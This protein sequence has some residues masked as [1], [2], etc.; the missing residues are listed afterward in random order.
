MSSAI[1]LFLVQD[2]LI[3]GA[4]YGLLAVAIV[5]VFAVTRVILVPQ[6]EFVTYGALTL[7]A[8]DLGRVPGTAWLLPC[9]G[10]V[11]AVLTLWRERHRLSTGLVGR[12]LLADIVLPPVLLGLSL[13]LA[14]QKPGLAVTV[15]LTMALV[16]PMGPLVYRIAFRPLAESSILVLL[17][18]A[19]GVHLVLTGL[20]LL[21]FGPEGYR[22]PPFSDATFHL[23]ILTVSGQS[24]WVLG[25]TA[26][27]L[28]GL[29]L[30]F[31]HTLMGKA[32]R[33][34]AVSRRGATLVGITAELS[35]S[36]AFTMAATIGA[37]SGLLIGP[38]TTLYYDSGFIIGLK[39]FVAAIVG[40]LTSYP[41]TAAAALLVGQ[42]EAFSS[43]EASAYKEVIVFTIIIPVLLWRSL[44]GGHVE[45]ED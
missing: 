37:L 43:F 22:T 36:V 35:G 23:G 33:A 34:S 21:F 16:V 1:V 9:L 18:A 38:V 27:L 41:I 39:G 19:V 40:G 44:R 11:A 29:Y 3:N 15:P 25:V 5:L 4:V 14:P 17:I 20:G 6:G 32:L 7:A 30:F 12:L 45:E 42:V 26:S 28:G 2:G 31:Q 24:L 13:W 10:A 8:L